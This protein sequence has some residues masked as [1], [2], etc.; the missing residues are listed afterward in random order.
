MSSGV[1]GSAPGGLLCAI[2]ALAIYF[3]G[4]VLIGMIFCVC[5]SFVLQRRVGMLD[6]GAAAAGRHVPRA[7]ADYGHITSDC[8]PLSVRFLDI[9]IA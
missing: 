3:C 4:V 7:S 2:C 9:S 5:L 1:D 6:Q 8:K